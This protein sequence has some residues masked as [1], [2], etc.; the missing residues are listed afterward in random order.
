MSE[1]VFQKPRMGHRVFSVGF[2]QSIF[3]KPYNGSTFNQVLQTY[4]GDEAFLDGDQGGAPRSPKVF[5]LTG[6]T[7]PHFEPFIV[8]NYPPGK[9]DKPAVSW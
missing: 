1:N 6:A 2:L 4:L 9:R 7:S 3:G 8:G 5:A